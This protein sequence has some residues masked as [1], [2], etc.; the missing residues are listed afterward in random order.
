MQ[1]HAPQPDVQDTCEASPAWNDF[2]IE[3]WNRL[4]P[5]LT[6]KLQNH[7]TTASN[8][9]L[10]PP[11]QRDRYAFQIA[12]AVLTVLCDIGLVKHQQSHAANGIFFKKLLALN[13]TVS[14]Q[15]Q[16]HRP[17]KGMSSNP[18]RGTRNSRKLSRLIQGL[19]RKKT[20][21]LGIFAGP[22]LQSFRTASL[23]QPHGSITKSSDYWGVLNMSLMV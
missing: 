1:Y 9:S 13:Q 4:V 8:S 21:A 17:S 16:D 10:H 12:H 2:S 20:I 11:N 23:P 6:P 18:T 5:Y 7:G 19:G 3:D 22:D 15:Q 14:F